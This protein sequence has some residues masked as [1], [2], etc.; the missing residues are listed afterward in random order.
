MK[1]MK[2][3]AIMLVCVVVVAAITFVAMYRLGNWDI[4]DQYEEPVIEEVFEVEDDSVYPFIIPMEGQSVEPAPFNFR[5]LG[6][7][8]NILAEVDH[9]IYH[10]AVTAPRGF[11]L[12]NDA[13]DEQ[14]FE[15]IAAYYSK[16]TFDPEMDDAIESVLVQMREIRDQLSLDSDQYVELMTRFVQTIPYDA[17]RGFV[18]YETKALGDPRM[19]V[20][21]LVDGLAD[22]DEKVMLLAAMLTREGFA[23]AALLFEAEQHMALG[24]R[25][26]GDGFAGTG[27]E[28]IETTSLAYVSEVPTIFIGG[29]ELESDPVVLVLDPSE[30]GIERPDGYY[31]L[32]A[33]E[34]VQRILAILGGAEAAS[35]EKRDYIESTPM[36]EED[37]RRE[38]ALF[39]ATITAMNTLRATVDNLG[40]DTGEFKDR[41]D[42]IQWVDEHAWWE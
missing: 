13:T 31:S 37:F 26:E 21:V 5:F 28:F 35:E 34:Q 2:S 41:T 20:Q 15:A 14:R 11:M 4:F 17:N 8:F 38:S 12:Q 7:D 39:E 3:L 27:Y 29:I 40:Q 32:A 10:G 42:A 25:S 9:R 30:A 16:M 19:P 33:A 22:C 23:T 1:F 6:Q 18:D 36:E 24:I